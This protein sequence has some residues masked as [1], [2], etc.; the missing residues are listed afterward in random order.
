[1]KK[2]TLNWHIKRAV[3][4][5]KTLE[6]KDTLNSLRRVKQLVDQKK[7]IEA[8]KALPSME[9]YWNVEQTTSDKNIG[10]YFQQQE[11]HFVLDERHLD[12]LKIGI[13]NANLCLSISVVFDVIVEDGVSRDELNKWLWDSGAWMSASVTGEWTY[14]EDDGG[15]FEV[16]Q[17]GV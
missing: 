15:H 6:D 16:I 13:Q 7:Y 1:M 2:M 10:K 4:D 12:N 14:I 8:I 17:L 3:I 9:F 5:F 11:Y